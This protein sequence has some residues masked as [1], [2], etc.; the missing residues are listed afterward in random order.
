MNED[1]ISAEGAMLLEILAKYKMED[2]GEK[3]SGRKGMVHNRYID[4]SS[5]PSIYL[6]FTASANYKSIS[7]I[8]S[9]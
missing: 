5:Q 9:A 6:F 1:F 3:L 2:G 8:S 7:L 4:I